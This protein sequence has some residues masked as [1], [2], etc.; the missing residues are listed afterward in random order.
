M[1]N[2]YNIEPEKNKTLDLSRPYTVDKHRKKSMGFE[3][4]FRECYRNGSGYSANKYKLIQ[5]QCPHFKMPTIAIATNAIPFM[6]SNDIETSLDFNTT[7]S[8]K[9]TQGSGAK[10]AMFTLNNRKNARFGIYS[11]TVKDGEKIWILKY[12]ENSYFE[13][14]DV[15]DIYLPH[16]KKLYIDNFNETKNDAIESNFNIS[17]IYFYT[18]DIDFIQSSKKGTNTNICT[19]LNMNS[20]SNITNINPDDKI[21]YYNWFVSDLDKINYNKFK[22]TLNSK[23]VDDYLNKEFKLKFDNVEVDCEERKAKISGEVTV[24]YFLNILDKSDSHKLICDKYGKTDSIAKIDMNS[25]YKNTIF[26][27][28]DRHLINDHFNRGNLDCIYYCDNYLKVNNKLGIPLGRHPQISGSEIKNELD[29]ITALKSYFV[30]DDFFNNVKL[31]NI[32]YNPSLIFNIRID[33]VKDFDDFN[34]IFGPIDNF[35]FF[36]S[37][38]K[39]QNII[40][41][42]FDSIGTKNSKDLIECVEYIKK[43]LPKK[44]NDELMPIRTDVI[45]NNRNLEIRSCSETL[46]Y[47]NLHQIDIPQFIDRRIKI[48]PVNIKKLPIKI[49]DVDKQEYL[50]NF[51]NTIKCNGWGIEI[52]SAKFDKDKELF[53]MDITDYCYIEND[54]PI[55]IEAEKYIKNSSKYYPKLEYNFLVNDVLMKTNLKIDVIDN[56]TGTPGGSGSYHPGTKESEKKAKENLKN[57]CYCEEGPQIFGKWSPILNKYLFNT[58]N[59]E[60]SKACRG[61]LKYIDDLSYIYNH[62]NNIY[63][64][65][66]KEDN[67]FKKSKVYA[68]IETF[69]NE[70]NYGDFKEW[71]LDNFVKNY[72]TDNKI[73]NKLVNKRL[74]NIIDDPNTTTDSAK[75]QIQLRTDWSIPTEV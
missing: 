26:F 59:I 70:E 4:A 38:E 32:Q 15:T 18:Y 58:D 41:N 35:F 17:V 33:E 53:Y 74:I 46:E 5:Y 57:D 7:T 1:E 34:D 2:N 29:I 11:N 16:L 39:I 40:E 3:V 36:Y 50:K 9:G 68:P 44:N 48:L 71:M 63:K 19:T 21:Y 42:I 14:E 30:N 24:K 37:N 25:F 55:F 65:Y 28:Q 56:N 62:I 75:E 47:A 12:N 72:L 64:H 13:K 60:V 69:L 73:W 10:L 45:K 23:K 22:A 52:E 61:D 27:Y 20:F 43:F 54:E 66:Y 6:S 49:Y 31:E 8:D 51:N 67:M